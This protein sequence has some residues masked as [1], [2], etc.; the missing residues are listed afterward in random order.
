MR[1][2]PSP[3]S[4]SCLVSQTE[5]EGALAASRFWEIFELARRLIL[6]NI[7][8]FAYPGSAAQARHPACPSSAFVVAAA[9]V[10]VPVAAD[11]PLCRRSS[12]RCPS[13]SSADSPLAP[14]GGRARTQ[15]VVGTLIAF[16]TLVLYGWFRPHADMAAL[17]TGYVAQLQLFLFLF[18][19]LLIKVSVVAHTQ[20]GGQSQVAMNAIL[21]IM[22]FGCFAAP[23]LNKLL[24]GGKPA[25][26]SE[27]AA[28]AAG[29]GVVDKARS[30]PTGAI[31]DLIAF[32]ARFDKVPLWLMS[33]EDRSRLQQKESDALA[34]K[35]D[36][37][38]AGDDGSGDD[39]RDG[40]EAGGADGGAECGE[41]A[42]GREKSEGDSSSKAG[43][44][45]GRAKPAHAAFLPAARSVFGALGLVQSSGS[46]L[47]M[48]RTAGAAAVASPAPDG[49]GLGAAAARAGSSGLSQ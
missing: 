48:A 24:T 45:T 6:T 1:C 35:I 41:R 7:I 22:L 43:M 8:S 36:S 34:D 29:S 19:A 4:G 31:S 14:C 23:L 18:T 32:Q 17:R 28:E 15:V 16:V 38:L 25:V 33:E 5:Q 20:D 12:H 44:P 21:T 30:M 27:A 26:D 11:V 47:P 39:D 13:P 2:L 3:I 49:G 40:G 10:V 9:E 37:A 46:R 42:R